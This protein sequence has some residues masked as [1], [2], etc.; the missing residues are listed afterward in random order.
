M[1]DG[2][3]GRIV[4]HD[5]GGRGF[6]VELKY[7]QHFR[8]DVVHVLFEADQACA[9]EMA[10][11]NDRP[12]FLVAPYGLGAVDGPATL[13]VTAN[14]Y[15]S[16]LLEPDPAFAALSCEV[17][18][19]GSIDG[20]PVEGTRYDALYGAEMRVVRRIPVEI[21]T[22]DGLRAAGA[23]P[24]PAPPDFLSIDTQGTEFEVMEGALATIDAGVLALTCEV[25]FRSMYLGQRLFPDLF[26]LALA[27][28]FEFVDFTHLQ[29]VAPTRLPVGVRG[30][31]PLAFGDALFFKSIASLRA[32]AP[33]PDALQ[34]MAL[35]LAFIAICYR[36][37]GIAL[38]ALEEAFARPMSEALSGALAGRRYFEFLS[39]LHEAA[40]RAPRALLHDD[41]Q[42]VVAELRSP[43]T[44][45]RG[46]DAADMAASGVETLLVE[47]GFHELAGVVRG[48]RNEARDSRPGRVRRRS[49]PPAALAFDR[50]VR[51]LRRA[52]P[53][54]LYAM[55]RNL[56]H[57]VRR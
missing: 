8:D 10:R 52:V 21:R 25:E 56:Y 2:L 33:T 53:P 54:R 43:P 6:N 46:A 11:T 22:L 31:E 26:R 4:S 16:S 35:K 19:S 45:V 40:A 37:L 5:V 24:I 9:A 15:F 1:T 39:A 12:G 55:L 7:P 50:A 42:A 28:G 41:R 3:E 47:H 38:A 27:H 30:R 57:A 34:L 32:I 18:L 44:Q 51:L 29:A 14:P 13:H 36:Q 17:P 23:L 20:V 49:A 48:R